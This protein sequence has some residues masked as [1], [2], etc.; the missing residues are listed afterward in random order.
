MQIAAEQ[1]VLRPFRKDFDMIKILFVCHGNICRSV[2]A[3]YIFQNLVNQRGCADRFVID[4][5][6][7][8]REEIGNPIYPPMASELR[9]RGVPLG[10]HRARQ[11]TRAEYDNWDLIIGMDDENRSDMM[12]ILGS[13]P[14]G[15]VHLLM[16]YTDRPNRRIEDP[17][18]TDRYGVV[19]DDIADGCS[20]LLKN[21]NFR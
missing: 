6:A 10:T 9:R 3:Q 19:F 18:W 2:S 13:D 14:E 20:G 7:A 17:W 4:S 8:T 16:E 1:A 5:A 11:L 12:R 21:L 15:K